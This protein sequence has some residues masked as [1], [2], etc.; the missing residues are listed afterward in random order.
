MGVL[1]TDRITVTTTPVR[2]G[3][4]DEVV[5]LNVI[6][7]NRGATPIYVGGPDV[8]TGWGY[9]VDPGEG[10]TMDMLATDN[11]IWALTASGSSTV[12]RLQRG[13]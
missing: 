6:F 4:T 2:I 12:H 9:Q 8:S 3:G 1:K 11:G 7:R 13:I 10:L 5:S